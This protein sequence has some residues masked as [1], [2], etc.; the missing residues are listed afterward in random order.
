MNRDRVIVFASVSI[1]TALLS[2][3]LSLVFAVMIAPLPFPEGNQIATVGTL[4][5]GSRIST[6]FLDYRDLSV[7]GGPLA[8]SVYI[9]LLSATTEIS[10][11]PNSLHNVR[12]DGDL[13][14]V[15]RKAPVL[16]HPGDLNSHQSK[17]TPTAVSS[18]S[19]WMRLF[20][21]DPQ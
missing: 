1:G 5:N 4:L 18:Y 17:E 10:G 7:S 13:L 6:S 12:F 20:P 3:M 2:S 16:G 11:H 15:F 9:Q 8:N 19:V 21:K 14:S